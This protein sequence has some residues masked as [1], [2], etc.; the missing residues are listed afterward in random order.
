MIKRLPKMYNLN[1]FPGLQKGR[2]EGKTDRR[3]LGEEVMEGWRK[4]N[5]LFQFLFFLRGVGMDL[6]LMYA[7]HTLC[8]SAMPSRAF[9]VPPYTVQAVRHTCIP[10]F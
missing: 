10:A 1:I 9:T 5:N 6:G 7:R 8:L 3:G 4:Q 2:K